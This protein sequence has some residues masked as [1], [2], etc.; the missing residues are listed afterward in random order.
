MT[1][2]KGEFF[3]GKKE[4]RESKGKEKSTVKHRKEEE[5]YEG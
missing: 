1:A 4:K 2:I 5:N 3:I